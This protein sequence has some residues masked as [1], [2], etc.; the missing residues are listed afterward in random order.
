[1]ASLIGITLLV[2]IV[3]LWSVSV[4]ILD[5][6][7][8]SARQLC[9]SMRLQFIDDSVRMTLLRAQ[10]RDGRLIVRQIYAFDFSPDGRVR[11]GGRVIVENRRPV[12]AE[13]DWPDQPGSE[14][15]ALSRA[16]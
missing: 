6:V 4:G 16:P 1:M 9:R 11:F 10:W 15:P 5:Q 8:T 13:L 12:K 7:R 2:A 14:P 3:G